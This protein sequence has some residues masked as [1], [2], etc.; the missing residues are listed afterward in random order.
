[1][2]S[3]VASAAG[4]GPA[5][6]DLVLLIHSGFVGE[7]TL[8]WRRLRCPA[9]TRFHPDALR[10]LWNG[11]PLYQPGYPDRATGGRGT[12]QCGSRFSALTWARTATASW[13]STTREKVVVRRRMHR[14]SVM[15]FACSLRARAWCRWRL[16]VALT[17]L[18]AFYATKG[19]QVRLMSPEY[20]RPHVR[21]QKNDDRD[22]EAIARAATRPTMRFDH[23]AVAI[24]RPIQILPATVHPDVASSTYPAAADFTSAT[25]AQLSASAGVSFTSQSRIASLPSPG[26]PRS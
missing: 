16:A 18:A 5:P 26:P 21:T 17:I 19:H 7:P 1:V 11:P 24:D 20:L 8:L 4:P 15:K 2:R 13:V 10:V 9:R 22:A 23:G 6:G 14:D 12:C 3:G 25:V